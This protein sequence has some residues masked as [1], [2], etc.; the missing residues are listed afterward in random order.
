MV[1]KITKDP[2]GIVCSVFN[3]YY[4][5]FYIFF[6]LYEFLK[7]TNNIIKITLPNKFLIFWR[8]WAQPKHISAFLVK[9]NVISTVF[10]LQI[11]NTRLLLIIMSE[12]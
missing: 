3:Q 10:S 8:I 7:N 5:Y 9:I 6:Q 11:I 1:N 12:K 2:I 4:Q